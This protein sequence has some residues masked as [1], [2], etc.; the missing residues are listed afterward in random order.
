MKIY[1][2][3][4]DFRFAVEQTVMALLPEETIETV[5]EYPENR[6]NS[7]DFASLV[8]RICEKTGTAVCKILKNQNVFEGVCSLEGIDEGNRSEIQFAIKEAIFQATCQFQASPPWGNLTGVRP[9]KLVKK[10]IEKEKNTQLEAMPK[11]ENMNFDF[12]LGDSSYTQNILHLLEHKYHLDKVRRK[13]ALTCAEVSQQIENQLKDS[14]SIYVGIPFCPSR[15]HYC[16]FFSSDVREHKDKVEPYLDGLLQEMEHLG[17]LI[18]RGN[19]GKN[20]NVSTVYVGGGTPTVLDEKQLE[21]LLSAIKTA[22]PQELLEFTVEAGRPDTITE[23][24]LQV[25][26]DY[27]VTRISINPQTMDD[28]ILQNMGRCHTAKQVEMV[29]SYAKNRFQVNTD[30]ICGLLGDTP[31]GFQ[32][33]LS[34]VIALRPTQVTVHSLTPKKNTPLTAQLEGA[35]WETI[36]WVDTLNTAWDTL[37][38]AGYRPYYLY[39]QK[40]IADGLENVGWTLEKESPSL[41]NVAMMEEFQTILGC[42]SGAMTKWVGKSGQIERLQNP[43]FYWDYLRSLPENL[44]KKEFFLQKYKDL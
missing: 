7:P 26:E 44:E 40:K 43:K 38:Q 28:V 25:L 18:Q 39:R 11:T 1:L 34:Q 22:F 21:S 20:L 8:S 24:K 32:K 19:L 35:D 14:V 33:S 9:V 30:L 16:S 10:L 2:E 4:H 36:S 42:G 3:N 31:D 6:E 27:K 41:Y 37:W 17:Q 15:C 13:L 5:E 12:R 23:E 29:Y